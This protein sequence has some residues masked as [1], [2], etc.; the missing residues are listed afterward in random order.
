[1]VGAMLSAAAAVVGLYLLLVLGMALGQRGMIY[2]PDRTPDDPETSGVPD[3]VPV[4]LRA[5]DGVVVTG[6][7][8]PPARPGLQT[9][10]LFH[11]NAGTKAG[12]AFKARALIAAGHG[13]FLAEYRGYAGNPGR[14]S[15][16]GLFADARA[17]VDWL[18]ARGTPSGALVLYGESLGSGVATAMATRCPPRALILECP[19]TAI[20]DLAPAFVP[21]ALARVLLVDRYDNLGR[22][23]GLT[24][25]LLVI[26]GE[27][28]EVVPVAQARALLARAAS[29]D[30]QGVFLALAHHNDLWEFGAADQILAFLDGLP[31]R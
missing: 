19:F 6:W 20:A 10:V 22:I 14:P 5:E 15:E 8:A 21:A 26:H 12:R 28:D 1:M 27:Q 4:P 9:V 30:K 24:A 16:R 2:V 25:P 23:G 3:M 29:A 31:R 7:Y 11:G 18:A 17:V 13:V